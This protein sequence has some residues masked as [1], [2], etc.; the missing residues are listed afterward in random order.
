MVNSSS[1]SSSSKPAVLVDRVIALLKWTPEDMPLRDDGVH[2]GPR[3]KLQDWQLQMGLIIHLLQPI[4]TFAD[5]VRQHLR[6]SLSDCALS[7][8]RQKMKLQPFLTLMH[9]ALSPLAAEAQQASCFFKGLRLVGHDGTQFSVANT[10]AVLQVMRKAKTRRAEA[11][12]AKVGLGTLVELGTHNPLA[13]AISVSGESES[14]LFNRVLEQ[15]PAK[16]LLILD[17]WYGNAP[18]LE[19]IGQQCDDHQSHYLIRARSNIKAIVKQGHGDGSARVEIAL[20]DPEKRS[21]VVKRLEVR[22]V[23]ARLRRRCDG[24]WVEVR[25]WTSLSVEQADARQVAELYARRW[26]QEVFYKELKMGLRSGDLLLS[27]TPET[28]AQE[29]AALLLAASLV[30]EERLACAQQS[31]E[32]G[33]R[34]AGVMRISFGWCVQLTTALWMLLAVGADLMDEATQAE[35]VRRTREQI[36]LHALPKRRQRTCARK[37]RQPV[38]KWPRMITPISVSSETQLEVLAIA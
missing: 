24:K 17:R 4:G 1:L 31:Q 20:K 16:S 15:L 34:Q 37:L 35:L 3:R 33:V 32:E 25:L 29:V 10:P 19:R 26:E 7:L 9:H 14:V 23:R 38:Q 27:Q 18:M 30:A 13:A 12:F 11:A 22:E 5:C 36:A 8:R 28:A 6:L 21:R 2:R